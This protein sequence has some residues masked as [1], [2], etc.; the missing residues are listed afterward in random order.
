MDTVD[1]S[2]VIPTYNRASLIERA[3]RSAVLNTTAADEIIVVDDGSTDGTEDVLRRFGSRIKIVRGEHRGAGKARNLGVSRSTRPYIAFLDSDDEWMPHKMQLQRTVLSKYPEAVFSCSDFAVKTEGSER[4]KFLVH[5]ISGE[6]SLT[7]V[8]GPGVPYS[9]FA[10]L[11]PGT[12]DFQIRSGNVYGAMLLGSC[13]CTITLVVNRALA[14]DALNF[15]EDLP[16]YEDWECAARLARV[17]PCVFLDC[18]TAWNHG[19]SG[20][21]LTQVTEYVS[22]STR[23]AVLNRVWG[24][25]PQFMA[26]HGS[27]FERVVRAHHLASARCLIREGRATEAREEIR[28]AGQVPLRDRAMA[29]APGWLLPHSLI[30]EISKTRDK[31]RR[32]KQ[33]SRDAIRSLRTTDK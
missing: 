2:V 25:D 29:Y 26:V 7:E 5:W 23:L 9:S 12:A 10:P 19:H 18:E 8:F 14:G 6:P 3:I 11:P 17:G 22:A 4:H 1:V 20:P 30:N 15:P 27:Q 16:T 13:V 32:R 31:F 28:A 24:N 33:F 21:R